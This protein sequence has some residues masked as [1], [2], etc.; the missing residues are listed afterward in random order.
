MSRTR[1]GLFRHHGDVCVL[2]RLTPQS[3]KKWR[4]RPEEQM[5]KA[6]VVKALRGAQPRFA[7]QLEFLSSSISFANSGH[8]FSLF[9]CCLIP[10]VAEWEPMTQ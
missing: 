2:L 8:S 7:L 4:D 6:Q 9:E 1:A 10:L 3:V 5:Q